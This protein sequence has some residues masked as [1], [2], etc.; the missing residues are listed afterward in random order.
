MRDIRNIIKSPIITE[1][2][3][4]KMES[5]GKY[6]FEVDRRANKIEIKAAVEKAFKVSVTQ[7]NTVS[8]RGKNK[9][10]RWQIGKTPEWKKAIVTL[11][12]GEKIEYGT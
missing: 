11:K 4:G 8:M 10:V 3:S 2:A 5:E 12:K 6:S 1:K 7:V 9:R